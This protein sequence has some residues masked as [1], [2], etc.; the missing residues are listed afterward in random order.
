DEPAH[1]AGPGAPGQTHPQPAVEVALER[2]AELDRPP[3]RV[4]G[5]PAERH[6]VDAILPD[7]VGRAEAA[8]AR[9]QVVGTGLQR[10][11]V[12]GQHRILD[13]PAVVDD[14]HA[15]RRGRGGARG[16]QRRPAHAPVLPA[17]RLAAQPIHRAPTPGRWASRDALSDASCT[18]SHGSAYWVRCVANVAPKCVSRSLSSKNTQTRSLRVS[19]LNMLNRI[20]IRPA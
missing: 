15:A 19:W 2:V 5:H 17:A 4:L 14:L 8:Q 12:A 9:S 13:A 11:E 18:S 10:R 20:R 6:A 7:E 16:E 1:D 3:A